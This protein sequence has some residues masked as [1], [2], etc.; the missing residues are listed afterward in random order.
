[1]FEKLYNLKE[2]ILTKNLISTIRKNTFKGNHSIEKL[3]L[4]ENKIKF[5]ENGSFEKLKNLKFLN[6]ESNQ[7]ESMDEFTF[8][9][10]SNLIELDL[11]NNSINRIHI[12]SL[13]R[14]KEFGNIFRKH[15]FLTS[16]LKWRRKNKYI[17]CY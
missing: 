5:I 17:L 14:K 7:I 15:K 6:I 11:K 9:G 16:I 13:K 8:Q 10:L 3:D 1:M 12:N 2:L 4:S